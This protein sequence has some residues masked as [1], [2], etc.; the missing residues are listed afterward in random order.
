MKNEEDEILKEGQVKIVKPFGPTVAMVKIPKNLIYAEIL[1]RRG[2]SYER[3]NNYEKS[4]KDLLQSLEIKYKVLYIRNETQN[5]NMHN[6]LARRIL[7]YE[8]IQHHF[9]FVQM[10]KLSNPL[11]CLKLF[12]NLLYLL[13]L[14]TK[15]VIQYREY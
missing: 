6:K 11:P 12:A 5:S 8:V 2:G 13:M 4:D 7:N 3:I 9:D 10:I 14:M 1:F 15:V